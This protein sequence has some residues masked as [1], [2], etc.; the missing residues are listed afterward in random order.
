[1]MLADGLFL[2][3]ELVTKSAVGSGKVLDLL[4]MYSFQAVEHVTRAL[5]DGEGFPDAG[6]VSQ[7]LFDL[8]ETAQ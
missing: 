6:A 4:M 7:E 5:T 3:L 2:A 1:M 8:Q